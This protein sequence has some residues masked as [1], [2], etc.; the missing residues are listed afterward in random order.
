ML[1]NCPHRLVKRRF[2]N[3]DIHFMEW[4]ILPNGCDIHT[5]K[6]F[7]HTHRQVLQLTVVS[8]VKARGVRLQNCRVHALPRRAMLL[9]RHVAGTVDREPVLAMLLLNVTVTRDIGRHRHWGRVPT[10]SHRVDERRYGGGAGAVD[11]DD[12]SRVRRV[13]DGIAIIVIRDRIDDVDL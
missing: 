13:S 1:K 8:D 11:D 9:R 7:R 12:A 4:T 5:R 10:T 3:V 2:H 6:C